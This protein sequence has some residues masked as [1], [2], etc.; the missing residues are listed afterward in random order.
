M[1][2]PLFPIALTLLAVLVGGPSAS[3]G[4]LWLKNGNNEQSMF[5]DHRASNIGDI[6][7][8]VVQENTTVEQTAR[9]RTYDSAQG[10][11]GVFV[12][13][14][15][16][17][18]LQATPEWFGMATGVTVNE[19]DVTIPTLDIAATGEW[20]GGGDT[21]DTLTITNRTSVT[22]VDVLPNGNLVVEGAKVI[23]SGK[24]SQYG[25]LRGVVRPLDVQAD[26]TVLST[27]IADAQIEFI[28]EGELTDAQKK[29]WLL[30]AW[31]SVKPF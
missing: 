15:L 19:G 30:R 26:N 14:L 2:T 16:N 23:R 9:I 11:F 31:D 21:E 10:G 12:N 29:G 8:V 6:L 7:T 22:V 18:F 13:G 5:A 3:A 24:E 28:P 27:Q 25:Y 1:K 17:Q 20:N 4:S